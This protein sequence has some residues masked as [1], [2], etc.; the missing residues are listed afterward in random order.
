[1]VKLTFCSYYINGPG[2]TVEEGCIWGDGSQ[3]IGNWA[4]YVAGANTDGSGNTFVK[5]AWNPI[6]TGCSLSGTPPTFG[7]KIVC[8]GNGCNGV[9]C[10]ID[11]S[12][13][14][15]GGVTSAD[16][17][18][19]AGG[20]NFCVV[21]VP[22]G[23]TANIVV[24][25]AGNSGAGSGQ[26]VSS[27][28]ATPTPSHT[29]TPTPS[30]TK[31]TTPS[32]TTTAAATTSASPKS[33]PTISLLPSSNSNTT[34]AYPTADNSPHILFENQTTIAT[35][36]GSSTQATATGKINTNSTTT[37]LAPI[38]SKKSGASETLDSGSILSLIIMFAV[39]GYLL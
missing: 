13:D 24:F 29:P 21:T 5:I 36:T 23:E 10:S 19:G 35:G 15:V 34:S 17:A 16:Q 6:W 11:P 31:S 18:S 12:V 28:S 32:T 30:S 25:E 3:P 26:A 37:G 38:S 27:S 4:P 20:A 9:P 7:V 39:A 14:G 2:V 22:P 1:M 33:S 8:S